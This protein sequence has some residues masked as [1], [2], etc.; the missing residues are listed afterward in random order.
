M[1]LFVDGW[2]KHMQSLDF[3]LS[4]DPTQAPQ[5]AKYMKNQFPFLGL[6]TPE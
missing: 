5:M 1:V 3:E 6:K 4:G 2:R